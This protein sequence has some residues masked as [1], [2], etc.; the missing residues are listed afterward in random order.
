MR[1][2]E[3]F[4]HFVDDYLAYL[5]EV[6]PTGAALDGVHT[7]DDLLEDLSRQGV[8]QHTRALS[9]FSRRLQDINTGDLTAAERAEQPMVDANIQARMFELERVRTWERNPQLYSDTLCSSLAAQVVFTHAP[10]P[11][12]AR[13]VLSK[14]R[15]TARLVQA[16]RDNIKDP[17]GI[18]VKVG[19]ETFRGALTFIEKDLPRAFAG[20]DDLHLL[21]DLA[22]ASTEA[23]QAIGSY[24]QHLD[25]E[26][27]PKAR[28]SF[29]LGGEV[30]ERKLKLDEGITMDAGRLL[31]IALREFSA[32]QEEFKTLAGRLDGG[33]PVEAWRKAKDEHPA[34]GQ[35][36][37]AAQAQLDEIGTFI[38]RHG[39]ITR[40]E[41]EPVIVAP[42]PEFHRWSFASMWVPG[43]FEQKPARA[44][45]FLT[46]ADPSWPIDK[47]AEHLRDFNYPALWSISIHEVYPGHFL[48]YQFLRRVESKVR[49]STMFS[50]ASFVEGWAH[51]AEQMMVEAGFRRDDQTLRLGQLAEALIRLARF[52]TSIRLHVEDWSVEQSMRFFRDECFMEEAGARREAERGTFDPTYLVYSVGKLMLLKL[53]RDYKEQQGS[54]YSLRAFHDQLLGNGTATFAAHR[55]LMLGD[56]S[57]DLLE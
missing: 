42:T 18:F 23:A 28:A 2:S 50:P 51:Y 8:E 5:H 21:G 17:P 45:Y 38:D 46:D 29:R 34:P 37:A 6:H 47:Q 54:K 19:R 13:R 39:I 33:D 48:H 10:L 32:T 20:L 1:S 41:S 56:S 57:G 4:H 25:D 9:G 12:R 43:P 7:H 30:F 11:E 14:L 27:A 40:P 36:S 52:I 15:Q 26:V 55:Q 16:A 31:A 35:L 3:P 24:I 53:R 49:K 22:D 44:Y